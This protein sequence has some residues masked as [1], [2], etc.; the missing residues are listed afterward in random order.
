MDSGQGCFWI[1][2]DMPFSR[3]TYLQC[4]SKF[5]TNLIIRRYLFSFILKPDTAEKKQHRI[6]FSLTSFLI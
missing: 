3:V 2:T 1:Q 4:T 5:W 6:E